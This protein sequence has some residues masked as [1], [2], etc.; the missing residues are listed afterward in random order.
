MRL[1]LCVL[2]VMLGTT[3]AGCSS[4]GEVRYGDVRHGGYTPNN[5]YTAQYSS[6][7]LASR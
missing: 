6:E 3:A 7:T 4:S 1:A 5:A 2:A